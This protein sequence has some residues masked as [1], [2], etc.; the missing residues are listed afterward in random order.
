[1]KIIKVLLVLAICVA[2]LGF[3]RGWFSLS[4]HSREAGSHKVEVSLTVDP[5]KV[6]E[7]AEKAKDQT[8][9]LTGQDTD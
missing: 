1:M 4:S 8:K 5:D 2:V 6:K 3:Y 7:D 9:S